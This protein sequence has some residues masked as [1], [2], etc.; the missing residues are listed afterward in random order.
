VLS[1]IVLG[2]IA[3]LVSPLRK[4]RG[5]RDLHPP[6]APSSSDPAAA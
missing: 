6:G 2:A 5:L 3:Y 4:G 1:I